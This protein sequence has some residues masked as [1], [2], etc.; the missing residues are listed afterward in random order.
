MFPCQ[1][2]KVLNEQVAYLKQMINALHEKL[3]IPVLEDPNMIE[4][5][6]EDAEPTMNK[7]GLEPAE[8]HDD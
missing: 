5:F 3:N 8:V 1:T 4:D 2:C 7:E 6:K